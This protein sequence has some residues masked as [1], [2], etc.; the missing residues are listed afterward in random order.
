ML[1][2]NRAFM[3][4]L[5]LSPEQFRKLCD[6]VA[7]IAADFLSRLDERE[8]QPRAGAADMVRA[9]DEPW[10]GDGLGAAAAA[11]LRNV[12]ELSR[13]QNGRFFGYVM[14]S[15]DP[16]GAAADLL[17]RRAKQKGTFGAR[18]R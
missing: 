16:A 15:G 4:R 5:E 10:P 8:I 6:E 11:Q 12:V 18:A 14:G 13:W 1:R 2:Y 17:P 3:A 9:F 7:D